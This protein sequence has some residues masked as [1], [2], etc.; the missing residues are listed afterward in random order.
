M[1]DAGGST[2]LANFYQSSILSVE[3]DLANTFGSLVLGYVDLDD[4]VLRLETVELHLV[5]FTTSFH[6][7]AIA[8]LES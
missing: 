2:V 3:D 7:L 5:V 4:L 8:H 1:F 6:Y